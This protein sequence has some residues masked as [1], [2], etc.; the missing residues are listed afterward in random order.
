MNYEHPRTDT[1]IVHQP[2]ERDGQF[3]CNQLTIEPNTLSR[4][5]GIDRQGKNSA[6]RFDE[7][8][9]LR[10]V[11]IDVVAEI[12]LIDRCEFRRTRIGGHIQLG[13]IHA[14]KYNATEAGYWKGITRYG[15]YYLVFFQ[16]D[17]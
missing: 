1:A 12:G 16:S 5:V 9:A 17:P 4:V 14:R 2:T 15:W 6:A 8:L 11:P 3:T 10:N 13:C 7:T